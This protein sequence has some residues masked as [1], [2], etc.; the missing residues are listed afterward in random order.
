M[1]ASARRRPATR[2]LV[3]GIDEVGR[4]PLAGPVYA[5]AVIL[6]PEAMPDGLQA[7]LGDSKALTP[8]QRVELAEALRATCAVAVAGAGVAEID[9]WN[10]LHASHLAMARAVAGLDAAPDLALVDGNRAPAL[11]CA[12]EC[13]VGGD[14]TVPAIAAASIVAKVARDRLMAELDAR[15]PG[16]GWARNMGY[17]TREHREALARLGPSEHHRRSFRP[18]RELLRSD[19]GDR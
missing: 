9:T 5:A 1:S 19:G 2:R 8:A 14:A 4:G 17:G 6:R 12:V 11:P 7:R 3:A 10:V 15:H 13:V 18:V 16:Y